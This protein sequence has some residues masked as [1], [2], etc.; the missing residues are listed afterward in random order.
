MLSWSGVLLLTHFLLNFDA[1]VKGWVPTDS[2]TRALAL[3]Y[4]GTLTPLWHD[5]VH[6]RQHNHAVMHQCNAGTAQSHSIFIDVT[7]CTCT[8]CCPLPQA[9]SWAPSWHC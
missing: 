8:H 4:S 3:I 7:N 1:V 6:S 2:R 9:G 5:G